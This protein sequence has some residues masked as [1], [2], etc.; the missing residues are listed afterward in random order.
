MVGDADSD[1]EAGRRAGCRT[2]LLR[3]PDGFTG[4]AA[5]GAADHVTAD[6]AA[7]VGWILANRHDRPAVDARGV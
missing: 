5:N 3:A 7:A 6:L 2:V 1:V 4:S